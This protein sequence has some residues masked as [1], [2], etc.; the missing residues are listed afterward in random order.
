MTDECYPLTKAKD[1][2][3]EEHVSEGVSCVNSS[4]GKSKLYKFG[5]V[6]RING[7]VDI[8]HEIKMS[9]PVQG[10]VDG[11][12]FFKVISFVVKFEFSYASENIRG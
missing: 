9:G 8:M 1:S 2:K 12:F 6:Y 10:N 11:E 4:S 7:E 5:Q 3:C